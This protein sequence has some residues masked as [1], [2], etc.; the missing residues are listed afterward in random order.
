MIRKGIWFRIL[1]FCV[2]IRSNLLKRPYGDQGLLISKKLYFD[3]G[4]FKEIPIMEDIDIILRI[5]KLKK[6]K[7][8]N[9]DIQT[10]SRRWEK[11]NIFFN[12]IK[13]AVL[14]Y[15]WSQGETPKE[16]FK[17]YYSKK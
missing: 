6:L 11:G 3:L 2:F 17:N 5:S 10:S 16:L 9:L 4:G 12:A 1:E 14:R 7:A 8:L 15:R 13:S